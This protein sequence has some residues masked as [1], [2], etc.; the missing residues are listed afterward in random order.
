MTTTNTNK[1]STRREFRAEINT[2]DLHISIVTPSKEATILQV[3][4]CFPDCFVE[5]VGPNA[6]LIYDRKVSNGLP[7]GTLTEFLVP[8][9]WNVN[10]A[11]EE[12]AAA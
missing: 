8:V 12:E 1:T 2:Q 4:K 9:Q 6:G 3:H 5:P 10:R 11:V 7:I